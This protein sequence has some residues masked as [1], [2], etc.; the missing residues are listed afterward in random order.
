VSARPRVVL[1]FDYGK[2]RI[3]VA[4][5]QELTQTTTPLRTLACPRGVPDWSTIARMI[6]EWRPDAL[7]VG[8]PSTENGAEHPIAAAARRFG[9][10]LHGRYRLPVYWVDER[11]SSYAAKQ[12]LQEAEDRYERA[13]IDAHAAAVILKTWLS[14]QHHDR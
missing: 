2:R 14:S 6:A 11:L 1:G 7:V 12:G 5:G 8:Q 4:V 3:G 10:Q 13:D 9:N